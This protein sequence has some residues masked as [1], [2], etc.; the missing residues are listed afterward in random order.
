M[1]IQLTPGFRSSAALNT[2]PQSLSNCDTPSFIIYC[3]SVKYSAEMRK[4]GLGVENNGSW[5]PAPLWPL[6]TPTVV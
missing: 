3:H 1:V 5:S 4:R 6:F 2:E